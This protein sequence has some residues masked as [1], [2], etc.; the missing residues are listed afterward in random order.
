MNTDSKNAAEM[1][2]GWKCSTCGESHAGIPLSFAADFPDMYANMKK[3]ERDVLMVPIWY[4]ILASLE[5]AGHHGSRGV[6]NSI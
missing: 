5:T 6:S 3:E 4:Q 1:S 2:E